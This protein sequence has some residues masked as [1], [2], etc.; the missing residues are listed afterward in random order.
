MKK[1][2]APKDWIPK[3][4]E[5]VCHLDHFGLFPSKVVVKNITPKGRVRAGSLLYE[6]WG[7]GRFVHAS[8]NNRC[9]TFSDIVPVSAMKGY[10]P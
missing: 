1:P 6:P 3:V 2:Q 4:G 9:T 7:E 8:R 5:I 10:K